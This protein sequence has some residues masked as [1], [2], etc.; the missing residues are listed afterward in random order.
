MRRR[1]TLGLLAL[2]CVAVLAASSPAPRPAELVLRGG[3]VYT[4]DDA[5]SW[6]EAVAVSGGK[7][8]FVGADAG[9][10]GLDRAGHEGRRAGGED[11]PAVVSRLAR[12]PG[13]GRRRGARVRPERP[14][15]AGG[16]PREGEDLRRGPRLGSVGPR[17]RLGPD[18]LS[19]RQSLEDA[20]R[21]HRPGPSGVSP[22]LGRA[23][24]LG[25]LE[26]AR[27]RGRDEGDARSAVRAH[28][29]G[30]G[31]GGAE[32]DAARGRG[33]ARLEVSPAEEREGACRRAA[34]GAA[35][36]ERIRPDLAR[37]G[38]RL[39]RGPRGLPGARGPG[40]ALGAR[41]RLALL[42]HR[43]GRG[44]DGAADRAAEEVRLQAPRHQ[45]RQDLRRRRSRDAHGLGPGALRRIPRR[46]R[47]AEP[48]AR[49][50][51]GARGR[52]RPGGVPDPRPRDRRPRDPGRP[53]RARG[54]ADG[55]RR[56]RRA[57]PPRAHRADRSRPTSRASGGSA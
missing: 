38:Q 23:L 19:R 25:Q 56:A 14:L 46:S 37:R 12:P 31:D 6:A 11:G 51:P 41:S 2:L 4:V 21:R 43:Q 36:R 50:V 15:H 27:D 5:R 57:P 55:Q 39:G 44:G 17:G 13:L 35:P 8:V 32:R 20:A 47:Q 33:G 28:R 48:G 34:R 52:L 18:G 22:G 16:D 40:G 29:A 1:K 54:G 3:A 45:R 10:E 26:G 7:I 24:G 53:R 9:G 42:R 49:G 30:P